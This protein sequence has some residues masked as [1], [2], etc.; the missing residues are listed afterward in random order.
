MS[1]TSGQFVW[2]DL[3]TPDVDSAVRF[4]TEVVGWETQQWDGPEAYT[5]WTAAGAPIGGVVPLTK[6]HAAAGVIPHWMAYVTVDD[7]DAA[8]TRVKKS[9]GT[10]VAEPRDIPN[11]GRFAVIRDPQGALIAIYR[12]QNEALSGPPAVGQ[13]SWHELTTSDADAAFAFYNSLLG[14]EKTSDFDMGAMGKY[15]M[16]GQ[17]GRPYGG[18]MN[19][20]PEMKGSPAWL[21]YVRVLDVKAATEIVRKLGGQ[22]EHG[23]MEVPGGDWV[24]L[25]RDPQGAPFAIHQTASA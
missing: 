20:P 9:G 10:I 12:P 15:Q 2:Y 21:C 7:V 4:Y 16:Y 14:W 24:T 25:C 13:F 5:M 22:V 3:M 11:T 18:M 23:P 8:V 19:M 6:E 17:H 1:D